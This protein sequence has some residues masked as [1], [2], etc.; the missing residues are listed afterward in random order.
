MA[1]D[2]KKEYKEYYM[3]PCRP[4]LIDVPRMNYIAVESAANEI[5]EAFEQARAGLFAVAYTLNL[6]YLTDHRIEGFFKY[7]VPPL[8][9][10]WR[11]EPLDKS[12]V[13]RIY[14]IRLPDFF[15]KEDVD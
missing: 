3:P 5:D 4:E 12:N 1:F 14:A 10:F 15:T 8:E 6:S 9:G 7:V 13:S 2:F 11:F